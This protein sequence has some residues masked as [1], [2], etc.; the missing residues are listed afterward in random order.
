MLTSRAE[1]DVVVE[2]LAGGADLRATVTRT[3][4]DALTADL[5]D[6]IAAPLSRLLKSGQ[7]VAAVELIGGGAR[8]PAVQ[9]ALQEVA[10]SAPL[11]HRLDKDDAVA[12]GAS[13]LAANLTSRGHVSSGAHHAVQLTDALP[14]PLWAVVTTDSGTVLHQ[15]ALFKRLSAVPGRSTI[16]LP[17]T[18]S[19][20]VLLTVRAGDSRNVGP[21]AASFRVSGAKSAMRTAMRAAGMKEAP[22]KWDLS[23]RVSIRGSGG[24]PELTRAVASV[25]VERI[26]ESRPKAKRKGGKAP[27][28]Q[29]KLVRDT[30]ES[31]VLPVQTVN[32]TDA[33][34]PLTQEQKQR[35]AR[36]LRLLDVA[37]ARK[38]SRA[39]ARND[40]EELAAEVAE[41]LA[42]WGC[43]EE[44]EVDGD[45]AVSRLAEALKDTQEW[46]VG[47]DDAEESDFAARRLSLQR[48]EEEAR[49]LLAPGSDDGGDDGEDAGEATS[50]DNGAEAAQADSDCCA[51]LAEARSQI[52]ALREQLAAMTGAEGA[53]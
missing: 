3:Q 28:P 29:S 9:R 17:N 40:L 35:M 43:G 36:R 30:L 38:L 14:Y 10:G 21:V 27:P 18:T 51:E 45:G 20:A 47:A 4:F 13:I 1:A 37:D 39:S 12:V 24:A 32:P 49:P 48:L 50:G 16:V 44:C 26:V 46:L 34:I 11:G 2:Q 5:I 22:E 19:S 6:A 41:A 25:P 8:M 53:Q 15:A 23:L 31:E 7:P 42:S 33:P 52:A